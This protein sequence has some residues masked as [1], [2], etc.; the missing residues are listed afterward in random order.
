[1]EK[2]FWKLLS[3]LDCAYSGMRREMFQLRREYSDEIAKAK[4]QTSVAYGYLK[5]ADAEVDRLTALV[6][7]LE[8]KLSIRDND[9]TRLE[10]ALEDAKR[11]SAPRSK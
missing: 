6:D 10:I 9:I 5:K 3:L 1:V 11:G 7:D 2:T 8:S 4:K